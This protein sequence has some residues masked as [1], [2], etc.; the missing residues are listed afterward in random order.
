MKLLSL[1]SLSINTTVPL[2]SPLLV[3]IFLL[4]VYKSLEPGNI[5]EN[6]FTFSYI[7]YTAW[8]L[9]KCVTTRKLFSW[10]INFVLTWESW[11]RCQF[12]WVYPTHNLLSLLDMHSNGFHYFWEIWDHCFHKYSFCPFLSF[13]RTPTV[14]MLVLSWCPS[15]LCSFSAC[16]FS[17][18]SSD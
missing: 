13:P 6:N 12:L 10:V 2:Q 15:D 8:G 17:F 1:A 18:C 7:V 16:F 9:Q 3:H 4:S 11:Q 14:H 5:Y